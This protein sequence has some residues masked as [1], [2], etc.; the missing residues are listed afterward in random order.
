MSGDLKEH[1]G[2]VSIDSRNTCITNL[3]F[4]DEKDVARTILRSPCSKMGISSG[5][6]KLVTNSV[7]AYK[8]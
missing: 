4:A 3:R 5:K 8:L 1:G 6:T 2:N 7:K